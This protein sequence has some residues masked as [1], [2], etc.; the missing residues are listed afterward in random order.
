[1]T[2]VPV[3]IRKFGDVSTVMAILSQAPS[4]PDNL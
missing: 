4:E 2:T 3:G 1:M